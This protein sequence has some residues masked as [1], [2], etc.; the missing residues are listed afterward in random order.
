M[1]YIRNR[2]VGFD[3]DQVLIIHNAYL[4]GDPIKT[5]RKE[6]TQLSGVADATLSGDMPTRGGGYDQEG[7]FRTSS[8]DAKGAVVL[9][10]LFVDEHYIPTLG[11]Q[12][13]KGRNFSQ[14][15]PHRLDG[16]HPQRIRRPAAGLERP[17]QSTFL[18]AERS[19]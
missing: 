9:T 2:E 3:R 1:N 15:F 18:S 12:M 4:A 11:M 16:H 5:F 8:M 10:N 14:R 6:L 19:G 17:H 13:V 7:W